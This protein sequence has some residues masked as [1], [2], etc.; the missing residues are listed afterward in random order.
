MPGG[1]PYTLLQNP[2]GGIDGCNT[3]VSGSMSYHSSLLASQ[4]AQPSVN[5]QMEKR[6]EQFAVVVRGDAG[7]TTQGQNSITSS[8]FENGITKMISN[9]AMQVVSTANKGSNNTLVYNLFWKAGFHG[10]AFA[11]K[12]QF[13]NPPENM[14]NN[15]F[16]VDMRSHMV[17][18]AKAADKQM[19]ASIF[20]NNY[21]NESN[22]SGTA[23]S[24]STVAYAN[25]I[26][27][28]PITWTVNLNT[29][30]NIQASG[31][32]IMSLLSQAVNSADANGYSIGS[33]YQAP[34][35][36][37]PDFMFDAIMT[38]LA[39]VFPATFRY[40][41]QTSDST[42]RPVNALF[43]T[44][45]NITAV[46]LPLDFFYTVPGDA[47]NSIVCL[48]LTQD[49]VHYYAPKQNG[50]L[51]D[52]LRN[53]HNSMPGFSQIPSMNSETLSQYLVNSLAAGPNACLS[54]ED[55]MQISQEYSDPMTEMLRKSIA[56]RYPSGY[57]F[58]YE[59]CYHPL[60][61]GVHTYDMPPS[62]VAMTS[63][64]TAVVI[65]RFASAVRKLPE[66]IVPIH[67]DP[68]LVVAVPPT[69][70]NPY[71]ATY[72]AF[73]SMSPEMFDRFAFAN[74]ELVKYDLSQEYIHRNG[75]KEN[76]TRE[77][78]EQVMGKNF[79]SKTQVYETSSLFENV[80]E[81]YHRIQNAKPMTKSELEAARAEQKR[82]LADTMSKV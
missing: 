2:E 66:Y 46:R 62:S 49:A 12:N 67:I 40:N 79:E 72:A 42:F 29:T 7:T 59:G 61:Y 31:Y 37:L 71:S 24:Q 5:M 80:L 25:H 68:S 15:E 78:I 1:V 54:Y 35:W 3:V 27:H 32:N 44:V 19:V 73:S 26:T 21:V 58:G 57:S 18:V 74:K 65:N 75:Q 36:L 76:T 23:M 4:L 30:T 20:A 10:G 16:H 70:S 69:Y 77:L 17:A 63:W 28:A 22:A 9:T 38:P 34:F 51:V 47:K 64:A 50:T 52:M 41:A 53:I 43:A 56:S 33:S 13:L 82:K 39:C 14:L 48:M 81:G 6:G 55:I 11:N 45:N 8:G 60:C